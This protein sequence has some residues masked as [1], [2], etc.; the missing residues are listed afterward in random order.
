[1][2]RISNFIPLITAIACGGDSESGADTSAALDRDN[3]GDGFP[4]PAD[5]DDADPDI[6]PGAPERCDGVDNDCDSMI[7]DDDDAISIDDGQVRFAD[8]DGDGFGDPGVSRRTC[9]DV[10]GLVD[11]DTDCADA[12]PAVHPAATE[13]CD[14]LDNDCDGLV[15]D[16]DDSL[17]TTSGQPGFID[18]DSDGHGDPTMPVEACVIGPETGTSPLGDDCDDDEPEAAPGLEETCGDGIDNDCSGD[19]LG[20]GFLR[21]TDSRESDL[22]ITMADAIGARLGSATLVSDHDADGYDDLLLTV[23]GY[24]T[25]ATA[26]VTPARLWLPGPLAAGQLSIPDDL[27]EPV[28]LSFDTFAAATEGLTTGD[29]DGDGSNDLGLIE[30]GMYDTLGAWLIQGEASEAF[31][32][33]SAERTVSLADIGDLDGDGFADIAVGTPR[34]SSWY[35]ELPGASN[36]GVHLLFGHADFFDELDAVE[37]ADGVS[38]LGEYN[39]SLAEQWVPGDADSVAALDF[40]G[41]GSQDLLIGAPN[42]SAVTA[43]AL[44]LMEGPHTPSDIDRVYTDAAD[45]VWV[46]TTS[47]GR[48]GSGVAAGDLNDDGYDDAVSG[49]QSAGGLTYVFHGSASDAGR[50]EAWTRRDVLLTGSEDGGDEHLGVRRAVEDLDLDGVPDLILMDERSPYG[51][52]SG[53]FGFLELSETATLGH[54]DAAVRL[55]GQGSTAGCASGPLRFGD[56]DADGTKDLVLSCVSEPLG[57]QVHVFFGSLD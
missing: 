55:L 18:A 3:D 30:S 43:G 28:A 2:P 24:R 20:C 32:T 12:D 38:F 6:H 56:L 53:A 7:D 16:R 4:T 5:C 35:G 23:P 57:G 8:A 11:D 9:S 50:H 39:A 52:G 17:D 10:P 36:G 40:N 48:M 51:G 31:I 49:E 47:G 21:Q 45:V 37:A 15:D 34:D 41:D 22:T 54:D 14:D 42:T 19:A 13:I 1:M 25:S 33:V 26:E 46:G 44:A 29:L 27:V